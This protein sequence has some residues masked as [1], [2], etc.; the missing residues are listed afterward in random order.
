MSRSNN[1]QWREII[2]RGVESDTLDY[3]YGMNWIKMSRQSKAKF[4]RHCLAFANTQG[5]CIVIG[6]GEDKSGHP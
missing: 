3:K 4:V 1:E 5:G 2:Y 6:V